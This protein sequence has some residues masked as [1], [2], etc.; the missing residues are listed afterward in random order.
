MTSSNVNE[1][2]FVFA[3]PSYYDGSLEDRKRDRKQFKYYHDHLY[4]SFK[5][6]DNL[7]NYDCSR[8]SR[9][10][11][12]FPYSI[13]RDDPNWNEECSYNEEYGTNLNGYFDKDINNNKRMIGFCTK[14][15]IEDCISPTYK[16]GRINGW[17][18]K[19]MK[20]IKLRT[21]KMWI[22]RRVKKEN[23]DDNEEKELI[24]NNTKN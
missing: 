10:G 22:G 9:S 5:T 21:T 12:W 13:K 6:L 24:T 15:N 2:Q 18:Y 3:R 7:L 8:R 19:N 11:W 4:F 23:D 14:D 16:Y 1:G 20:S 17:E